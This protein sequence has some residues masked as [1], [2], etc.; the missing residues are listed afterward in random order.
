MMPA[1]LLTCSLAHLLTCSLAHLPTPC[2]MPG[3]YVHI[4]FCAHACPYCDFSFEL[5][6][7]G[8]VP[9]YLDAVNIE[10]AQQAMEA[11]WG[12]TQFSTVFLGGG[13]PTAH[14]ENQLDT[15][16]SRLY[17]HFRIAP[18]A[19][20][21]VE[22]NPETLTMSKLIRLRG[23]GVNRISI[24]VQAFTSVSLARLGR[25]HSMDQALQAFRWARQAGFE[26]INVDLM[27]G[28]PD[29][30]M[31]DWDKTLSQ[32]IELG[33][34]HVS[35]YGLTV[36]PDTPFG[37]QAET[38]ALD[39]PDEDLHIAMYNHALDRLILAGYQ[40]YE[41][42]NLARSGF[43]CQ[44]NL[45]Y[46]NGADYLG[47]GPS[48]HSHVAGHRFANIRD[49]KPYLERIETG[50]STVDID[51]TLSE[52]ERIH[53]SIFLGL[54]QATGLDVQAFRD[55]FGNGAFQTRQASIDSLTKSGFLE[56]NGSHLR[57][58]RKGLAVADSVCERLM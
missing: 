51:E 12:E 23:L 48:A 55:Q 43:I 13:T 20:M 16:F 47:L 53:E 15:L 10:M 14:A 6:K 46:W 31:S 39:L 5:L 36:E 18:E 50:T 57:L 27:F 49:L 45:I 42:S 2:L 29:Q 41:V 25:H 17:T 34:D 35:T 56:Q 58:T 30:T 52:D 38:N 28:A 1:H 8:Q 26:N 24:G 54:R 32:A 40:H 7:G 4:P 33:P 37:R 22:A 44:H 19:E 21:T 11:V 3:L 9:R